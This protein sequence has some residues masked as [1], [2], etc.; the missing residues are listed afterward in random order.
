MV[1]KYKEDSHQINENRILNAARE[2]G[3]L[4][5]EDV[6]APLAHQHQIEKNLSVC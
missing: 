6:D 5:N 3:L 2:V 4:F 1:I